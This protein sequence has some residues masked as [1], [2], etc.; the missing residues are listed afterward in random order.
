VIF[1]VAINGILRLLVSKY[2]ITIPLMIILA[3]S[4]RNS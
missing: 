1:I 3:Q 2:S 4:G